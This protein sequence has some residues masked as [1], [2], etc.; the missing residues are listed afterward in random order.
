MDDDGDDDAYSQTDLLRLPQ[1]VVSVAALELFD[2]LG[3][4]GG[5]VVK[6]HLTVA[7]TASLYQQIGLLRSLLVTWLAPEPRGEQGRRVKVDGIT[8]NVREDNENA[9]NAYQKLLFKFK[10][11][12]DVEG[13]LVFGLEASGI[14]ALLRRGLS[15]ARPPTLIIEAPAA[16]A[17][18]APPRQGPPRVRGRAH[19]GRR[20]QH[21]PHAASCA[22]PDAAEARA[23]G[24]QGGTRNHRHQEVLQQ[25]RQQ[26]CELA[27]A[28]AREL[29]QRQ[30]EAAA[31]VEAENMTRGAAAV[32]RRPTV[33]SPKPPPRQERD[34]HGYM[35]DK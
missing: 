12:S 11:R 33:G 17:R 10:C 22:Q 31:A 6:Y 14:E 4:S 5:G 27:E 8:L 18:R 20:T 16:H 32:A 3:D 19:A 7:A 34:N 24:R 13:F 28:E 15:D 29:R 2:A 9:I 26:R 25:R 30:R 21:G 35:R 23:Q 1:Q